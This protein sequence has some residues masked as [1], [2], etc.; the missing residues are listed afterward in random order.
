MSYSPPKN[1][2]QNMYTLMEIIDKNK[3]IIPEG[4]YLN[5]CHTLKKVY[6]TEDIDTLKIKIDLLKNENDTLKDIC[7]HNY[8]LAN[9]LEA[10]VTIRTQILLNAYS[11]CSNF[12]SSSDEKLEDIIF[13]KK[14]NMII[15]KIKKRLDK[16]DKD[17]LDSLK[18]YE[19]IN[20]FKPVPLMLRRLL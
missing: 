4:D 20:L 11:K 8:K 14:D 10:L 2:S 3:D 1:Q 15:E 9:E 12:I 18:D 17:L 13:T 16:K 19:N 5:L 6:D 7:L